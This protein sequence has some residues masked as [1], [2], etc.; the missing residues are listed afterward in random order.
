MWYGCE[1]CGN[2]YMYMYMYAK[3][4]QNWS[5]DCGDM[6]I[7]KVFFFNVAS[8]VLDLCGS[9]WEDHPQLIKRV[10]FLE[11]FNLSPDKIW[12]EPLNSFCYMKILIFFAFGWEMPIH[13]P[14][15]WVFGRLTPLNGV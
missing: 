13:A 3:F 7:F 6:A 1:Y 9:F 12:L 14:K 2:K 10:Y 5:N 15:I 4:R 8:A 11:V